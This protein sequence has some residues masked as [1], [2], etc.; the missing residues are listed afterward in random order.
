MAIIAI[1]KRATFDYEVLESYQA[2]LSLSGKMV[3]EIR[4]RK[5]PINGKFVVRQGKNL[6]IIGLGNEKFL[7]NV[8]LLLK[9]KEKEKVIKEL[10]TKGITCVILT[11]KTVGRWLKA[12]IAIVKGKK[13]HNKKQAKKNADVDREINRELK[14]LTIRDR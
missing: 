8:T 7:E 12:D 14:T 9:E 3:K 11:I 6:Q 13:L 1:N 4:A 5:I 10:Q 2:G